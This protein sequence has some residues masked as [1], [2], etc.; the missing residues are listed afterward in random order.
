MVVMLPTA[1]VLAQPPSGKYSNSVLLPHVIAGKHGNVGYW[2]QIQISNINLQPWYGELH[3]QMDT[4]I[5]RIYLVE[6]P[7]SAGDL[8]FIGNSRPQRI[9]LSPG[10]SVSFELH[11]NNPAVVGR[12]ML[13][14][15]QDSECDDIS[16]SAF[17]RVEEG[18]EYYE[19]TVDIIDLNSKVIDVVTVPT[20][21]A[22]NIYGSAAANKVVSI[23]VS[24]RA[25]QF[26]RYKILAGG[27]L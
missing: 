8:S 7:R 3:I 21:I 26:L 12:A 6:L 11:S 20:V 13:M 16:V 2:T 1:T 5:S 15:G 19:D 4:T 14:C 24:V 22:G 27:C 10:A 23:P 18:Y 17:Y 9:G 25:N